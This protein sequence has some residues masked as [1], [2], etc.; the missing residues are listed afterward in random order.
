MPAFPNKPTLVAAALYGIS[1]QFEKETR[2]GPVKLTWADLS[3]DQRKPF[4]GASEYLLGQSFGVSPDM[5][6]RAKLATDVENQEFPG[7]DADANK[8]VAVFA[9]IASVL[10]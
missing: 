2:K 4:L 8:I 6:N 10:T 9:S 1:T 3:D 7:L 5:V